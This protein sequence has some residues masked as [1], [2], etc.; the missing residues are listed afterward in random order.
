M[1]K[2][3]RKLICPSCDENAQLRSTIDEL[4]ESISKFEAMTEEILEYFG[5]LPD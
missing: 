3:L 2:W 4:S 5:K 1:L